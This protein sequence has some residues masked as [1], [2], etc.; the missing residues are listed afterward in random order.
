[1]VVPVCCGDFCVSSCG[2]IFELSTIAVF[3]AVESEC[4]EIEGST[5]LFT[6]IGIGGEEYNSLLLL[7]TGST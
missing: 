6:K 3:L 5:G 7:V 4:C 2:F 1:M